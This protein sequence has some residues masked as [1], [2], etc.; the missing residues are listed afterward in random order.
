MSNDAPLSAREMWEQRYA[1]PGY[2][3]GTEPN[4]FLRDNMA[5]IPMGAVLCLA[6]GEGRNS[7]FLAETGR[8]VH[9][10]DLSEAGVAKTLALAAERGV[11]VHAIQADLA[12]QDIGVGRWDA[13]VSVFAHMPSKVRIDLHRR[14][15][16]SL[17]PGGVLVLEAYTPDQIG[18][19]TGGPA[20]PE[21]TMTLA[22]LAEELAGLEFVH[23]Q[24]LL[25][26]VHEG[27][28]H[29]GVGAV[30]QVIARK[31]E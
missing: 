28:G 19:G 15:V 6:E 30:V 5:S 18:R 4:T 11:T 22:G 27:P 31:P 9:S 23:A 17:R 10:A 16:N 3:Y 2:V 13:V 7:V 12:V 1:T 29:T 21:M 25:R 24:E 14:V 26:E 20:I 8:E